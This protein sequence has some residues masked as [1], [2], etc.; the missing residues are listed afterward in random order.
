MVFRLAVNGVVL[1][2]PDLY[3]PFTGLG[4][5]YKAHAMH[6]LRKEIDRPMKIVQFFSD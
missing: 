1:S 6:P 3:G 2:K 5:L 4:R